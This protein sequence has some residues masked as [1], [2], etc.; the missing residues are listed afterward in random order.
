ML[1]K[2]A[3][4]QGH[5]RS[6]SLKISFPNPVGNG[7][8]PARAASGGFMLYIWRALSRAILKNF[9]SSKEPER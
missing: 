8:I 1:N 5:T 3:D 7:I 6:C 4:S 9:V 2:P